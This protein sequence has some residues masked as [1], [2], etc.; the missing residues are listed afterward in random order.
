MC[1]PISPANSR[2]HDERSEQPIGGKFWKA[3]LTLFDLPIYSV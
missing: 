1:A 2:A 3:R